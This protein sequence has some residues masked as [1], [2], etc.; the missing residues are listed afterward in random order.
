MAKSRSFTGLFVVLG[1]AVA[2]FG[3]W[4]LWQR[5]TQ[6]VPEFT[7]VTVTRGEITQNVTATGS[8]APVTSIDVSSQISGLIT[9]VAVD[10]NSPVKTG[11]VLARIDPATYQ[12]RLAQ[13]QA[14]LANTNANCQLVRLNTERTRELRAKNLVSQQELD[15]ATAQL[16]QAEAQLQIQTATVESAKVDLARCSI[17][18]PI[19]GIVMDRATE[20]GKTVA[21]NFNAPTLFTIV[22]DLSKMEIEA[23]VAEADI[24]TVATGQRVSFTVDAFPGR[25][26]R[27]TVT[28]IRN[29]PKTSNNVVTY[30]TIISVNNE[31]LKLKPGMTANVSI[32]VAHRPDALRVGNSALRA[33][34][35]DELLQQRAAD[36]AIPTAKPL[37]DEEQRRLVRELYREV[38]VT[39]GPG[40]GGP[41]SPEAR[42]KVQQLA[43]ERGLA[44]DWSR[45]GR[46]H[47][48]TTTAAEPAVPSTRTVYRLIGTDPAT[49][50]IQP[51]TVKLGITD[52][53]STEILEGLQE[54]DTLITTV[55]MRSGAAAAGAASTANPFAPPRM[56][57]P[58]R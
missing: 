33:R 51:V 38:G 5:N 45:M 23:A 20:V 3:G 35:A 54:G 41:P 29:A 53:L 17:L 57:P 8:L 44:I 58:R 37:S 25:Q 4:R 28:Q 13:A 52:G 9:A 27:G 1:L 10:Y 18:A 46:R 50:Q 2:G 34:V 7:T 26:F 19:D 12:S 56:G 43:Q 32:V 47:G 14:Q 36:T 55:T 16:A 39:V 11:D 49:A 6:T 24:G 31:D 40:A 22:D 15:Q 42:Q 21:A 30:A 48:D